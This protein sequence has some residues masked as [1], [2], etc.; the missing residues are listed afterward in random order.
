MSDERRARRLAALERSRRNDQET[1]RH[2]RKIKAVLARRNGDT[3]GGD[4]D[5]DGHVSESETDERARARS[6]F[7]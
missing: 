5:A 4:G 7:A 2:A 3:I 6:T 1:R